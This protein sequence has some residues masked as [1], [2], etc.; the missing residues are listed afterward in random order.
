MTE[1]II[2][3]AFLILPSAV[4]WFLTVNIPSVKTEARKRDTITMALP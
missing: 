1:A 2:V 4:T 3:W